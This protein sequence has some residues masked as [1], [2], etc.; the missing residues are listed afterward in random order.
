[1]GRENGK[2]KSLEAGACLE[3][4]RN[5]RETNVADA[6]WSSSRV[7]E[8][9]ITKVAGGLGCCSE[10]DGK[11]FLSR[12]VARSDE[13]FKYSPGCHVNR[14]PWGRK[15]RQRVISYCTIQIRVAKIS[16]VRSRWSTYS[17]GSR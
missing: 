2:Y 14:L 12:M 11:L 9:E 6:E 17:T 13:H 15:W 5:S 10:Q 7:V 16:M 4:S 3:C 1:M 8:D